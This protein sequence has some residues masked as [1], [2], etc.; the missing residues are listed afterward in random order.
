MDA[1][2][3]F[4]SLLNSDCIYL[5]GTSDFFRALPQVASPHSNVS[6]SGVIFEEEVRSEIWHLEPEKA[7]GLDG[8]SISFYN[9]FWNVIKKDLIKMLNYTR[10]NKKLGGCTNSS[11]LALI[12][13]ESN[14]I[15]FSRFHPILLCNSSYKILTKIIANRIKPL[16]SSIISE[17]QGGFMQ[18][19][20]IL[21]NII[22]VQEVMHSRKEEGEV[23]MIIKLDMENAF[24]QVNHSFLFLLM[25][26]LGFSNEFISW[27][28]YCI[29]SPLVTPL[30][31]GRH[32]P[33]F[34][35][36]RGFLQRCPLSPLLYIIMAKA[37]SSQ[38]E[39]GW[40]DVSLLG[41]NIGIKVRGN[42]SLLVHR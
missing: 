9:L 25:E 39:V 2:N 15:S 30:I 24:G 26:K 34:T 14:P 19:R 1:Y 35:A 13:K 36:S 16:L 33:F 20:N 6:L 38:L 42:Q 12:P 23:G 27:I 8:F 21:D 18:H 22:L 17:N 40:L 5:E 31:N 28:K 10:V 7:L 37:L 32:A 3:H 29:G 4:K 41:L 11:F